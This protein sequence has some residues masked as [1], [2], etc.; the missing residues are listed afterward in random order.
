MRKFNCVSR[1]V[2]SIV[3]ASSFL[4]SADNSEILEFVSKSEKLTS[5]KINRRFAQKFLKLRQNVEMDMK[6]FDKA[7]E[8]E[9]LAYNENYNVFDGGVTD[10]PVTLF[11]DQDGGVFYNEEEDIYIDK[12]DYWD[13][14]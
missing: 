12:E 8:R 10:T 11:S 6:S 5:A 14:K 13:I 4:L 2:L 9:Y 3:V 1:I 7:I